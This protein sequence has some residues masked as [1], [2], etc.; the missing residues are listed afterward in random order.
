MF[1]AGFQPVSVGAN[2]RTWIVVGR[3]LSAA[4][5]CRIRRHDTRDKRIVA[6]LLEPETYEVSSL[7]RR[8][9]DVCAA[10]DGNIALI[11]PLLFQL[12]TG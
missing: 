9:M 6:R 8:R 4:H 7:S 10:E 5:V 12:T 3:H 1:C 2:G 11:L